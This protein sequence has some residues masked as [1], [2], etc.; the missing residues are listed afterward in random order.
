MANLIR[1]RQE[2]EAAPALSSSR[3]N[4]FQMMR[5]MLGFDPFQSMLA[6]PPA[7]EAGQIAFMPDFEIKETPEAYVFKADLPGVQESDLDIALTKNRLV[8][9]GKRES[10]SRNEG[11]TYYACERSYGSFTRA[12]TLPEGVDADN[13]RADLSNGVLTMTVPKKP[14]QQPK[15][16]EL[17][18]GQP[19]AKAKA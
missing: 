18:P 19:Q 16:I 1:R 2:S 14:E 5:D 7:F 15:K 11:E 9:S 6:I 12:F 13:V 3:F 4:P 17:K 8:V 10:E